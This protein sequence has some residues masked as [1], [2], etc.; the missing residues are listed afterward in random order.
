MSRAKQY[1]FLERFKG[2]YGIS[3]TNKDFDV[4]ISLDYRKHK[5]PRHLFNLILQYGGMPQA[6]KTVS[7]AGHSKTGEVK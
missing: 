1:A 6:G 2:E 5:T 4:L 3:M 7:K